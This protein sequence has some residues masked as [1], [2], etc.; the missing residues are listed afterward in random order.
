VVTVTLAVD[1]SVTVPLV[2]RRMD[3]LLLKN[4]SS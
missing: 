4:R 1:V 3:V 2:A